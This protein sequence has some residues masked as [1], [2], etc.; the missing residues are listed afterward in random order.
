M[1]K[2]VTGPMTKNRYRHLKKKGRIPSG[3]LPDEKRRSYFRA[4][5]VREKVRKTVFNC[6]VCE[7]ESERKGVHYCSWCMVMRDFK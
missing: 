5:P 2:A 3:K 6:E 1:A 4:P 7:T